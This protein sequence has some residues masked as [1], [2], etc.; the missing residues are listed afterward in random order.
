MLVEL[1]DCL[2]I[3]VPEAAGELVDGDAGV[4]AGLGQIDLVQRRLGLAVAPLLQGVEN[5][6]RLVHPAARFPRVRVHLGEGSYRDPTLRPR[7]RALVWS[8]LE[9]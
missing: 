1:V 3:L 4:I 7:L 5:V 6:G 2:G 8:C 9:L